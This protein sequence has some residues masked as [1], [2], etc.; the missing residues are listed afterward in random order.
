M[1]ER[2]D[3][4]DMDRA[5]RSLWSLMLLRG[6]LAVMFGLYALFSPES[7][8]LALVFVYGFYAIIDGVT[9]LVLGVRHRRDGHWGWQLV[10]GAVSLTAGLVALFW[11]GPTVFALVLIVA[12][13]S[14]AT[15]FTGIVEA[16]TAARH[17][18]SWGWPVVGGVV[19]ILFGIVLLASPATGT[20]L[21][22]WLIGVT[23]LPLGLVYIFWALRLRSATRVDDR[24]G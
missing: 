10:Q 9:A 4:R 5:L 15:G 24:V 22:L 19:G 12:V 13:W 6:V 16:F 21:L 17:G 20:F 23:T 14:I 3:D 18:E 1:N 8:L 11:P 7:A 2:T